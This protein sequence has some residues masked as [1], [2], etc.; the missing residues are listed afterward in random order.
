MPVYKR[1][2]HFHPSGQGYCTNFFFFGGQP[3][4]MARLSVRMIGPAKHSQYDEQAMLPTMA[5]L[6][7]T[8]DLTPCGHGVTDV[9]RPSAFVAT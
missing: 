5:V 6:P 9:V 3:H 4:R 7:L 1:T 2:L 8:N